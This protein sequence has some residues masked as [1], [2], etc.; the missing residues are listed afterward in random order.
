M[1]PG[2]FKEI[3]LGSGEAEEHSWGDKTCSLALKESINACTAAHDAL[4]HTLQYINPCMEMDAKTVTEGH[5]D[6]KSDE[7]STEEIAAGRTQDYSWALHCPPTVEAAKMALADLQ[8]VLRPQRA[9]KTGYTDPKLGS[10]LEEHL[11]AM[12]DFLVTFTD[13]ENKVNLVGGQ[14]G[15]QHCKWHD[16]WRRGNG[17]HAAFISGQSN[18][19]KIRQTCQSVN[20]ILNLQKPQKMKILMAPACHENG[21]PQPLYFPTG[22]P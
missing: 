21:D 10:V 20:G 22:H 16:G 9:D 5:S 11:Q 12:K 14:W 6:D 18:T 3:E 19:S 1:G 4:T 8:I 7:D 13:L 17:L 2:I 15:R